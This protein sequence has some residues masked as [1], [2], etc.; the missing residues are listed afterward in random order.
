MSNY[1]ATTLDTK[2]GDETLTPGY[3]CG[4]AIGYTLTYDYSRNYP[5]TLKQKIDFKFFKSIYFTLIHE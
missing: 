4:S 5:T 3:A 1:I 2:V